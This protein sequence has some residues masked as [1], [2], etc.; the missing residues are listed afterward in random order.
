ML[1]PALV[2]E[3][4]C[5]YPPSIHIL[6]TS[7]F[8][9]Q[10]HMN[11]NKHQALHMSYLRWFLVLLWKSS[12]VFPGWVWKHQMNHSLLL[13]NFDLDIMM[14]SW[15][16]P[17][18]CFSLCMNNYKGTI[19]NDKVIIWTRKLMRSW[20][21]QRGQVRIDSILSQMTIPT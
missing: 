20:M 17:I 16:R 9:C 13:Q 19:M 1:C 7:V 3:S 18:Y 21:I 6:P 14:K 15:N 11:E 8:S 12:I 10:C 2:E 5:L 4:F